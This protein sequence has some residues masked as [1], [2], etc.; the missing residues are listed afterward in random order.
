MAWVKVNAEVEVELQV[1]PE[2]FQRLI[3]RDCVLA[4]AGSIA[5]YYRDREMILLIPNNRYLTVAARCSGCH[6]RGFERSTP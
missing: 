1:D 2:E 4:T 5:S 3:R 6:R